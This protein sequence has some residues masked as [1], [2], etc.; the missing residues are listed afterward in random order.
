MKNSFKNTIF[1]KSLETLLNKSKSET[2]TTFSYL[3]RPEHLPYIHKLCPYVCKGIES[4]K[5]PIDKIGMR[6]FCKKM[7]SKNGPLEIFQTAF[8]S[9]TEYCMLTSNTRFN[10]HRCNILVELVTDYF[11]PHGRVDLVKWI[12]NSP[13]M[14]FYAPNKKRLISNWVIMKY[15]YYDQQNTIPTISND[16]LF[17]ITNFSNTFGEN[18]I[19][20]LT[21]NNKEYYLKSLGETK[22]INCNV[23]EGKHATTGLKRT[24]EDFYDSALATSK[25]VNIEKYKQIIDYLY[26]MHPSI[27][28]EIFT[29]QFVID[30]NLKFQGDIIGNFY[31]K[32]IVD[33]KYDMVKLLYSLTSAIFSNMEDAIKYGNVYSISYIIKKDITY[34]NN[35][36]TIYISYAVIRGQLEM[37]KYLIEECKC[38]INSKKI[39]D[40]T[41]LEIAKSYY[42]KAVDGKKQKIVI[43]S[44]EKI[45]EYFES[46]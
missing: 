37:V 4:M 11:I 1:E 21:I 6:N 13:I 3:K 26:K 5:L 35:L 9:H 41:L 7:I 27:S 28:K 33:K 39:N 44:L 23:F 29:G 43:D 14:T 12:I 2:D 24:L 46:K 20:K 15:Y 34:I 45:V 40:K 10:M 32:C 38:D 22:S 17:S 16:E 36:D 19:N 8:Y 42:Q 31:Q 18:Q 25:P 30:T